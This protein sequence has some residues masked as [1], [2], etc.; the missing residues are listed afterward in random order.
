MEANDVLAINRQN[1]HA[2]QERLDLAMA[3]LDRY[4]DE[5]ERL[6]EKRTDPG[7]AVHSLMGKLS[8]S[9][10]VKERQATQFNLTLGKQD[11]QIVELRATL[12]QARS[13]EPSEFGQT[14][15]E[16]ITPWKISFSQ[17]RRYIDEH[18][19]FCHIRS[20]YSCTGYE[21]LRSRMVNSP[22]LQTIHRHFGARLK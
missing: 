2:V 3:R 7:S 10:K 1:L 11:K 20:R 6:K 15:D 21:F 18:I 17:K 4:A 16:S 19:H 5:L 8:S 22:T 13:Y 9:R 14:G 12:S